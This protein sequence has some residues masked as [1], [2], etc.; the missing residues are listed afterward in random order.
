MNIQNKNTINLQLKESELHILAQKIQLEKNPKIYILSGDLAS[1]KT[2]LV[3]SFVEYLLNINIEN[4]I[5]SIESKNN[6]I[7]KQKDSIKEIIKSVSS[8]TFSL[9]KNYTQN[10]EHYDLYSKELSESLELGILDELAKSGWHFVEWGENLAK[11]LQNVGL[12]FSSI[13]IAR[14]PQSTEL[15]E[16]KCIF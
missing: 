3:R 11:I 9:W 12:K 1:G 6:T 15:R 5:D 7:I 14:V 4:K 16:Y 10:I 13:Q 2:T 8:P